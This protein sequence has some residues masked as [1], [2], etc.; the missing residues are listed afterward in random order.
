MIIHDRSFPHPVLAPFRDDVEPNTFDFTIKVSSDADNYYLNI[1]FQYENETLANL[2]EA[3]KAIHAVHIECKRNFYRH[4]FSTAKRAHTIVVPTAELVGKV[5]V[6]GFIK[7]QVPMAAYQITGAHAD[8][9]NATFEIK[10]GDVLAVAASHSFEAYVDYDPLRHISSILTI[11]RSDEDVEGDM[12]LDTMNDLIVVT[13]SQQDYDRYTGLKADPNLGP[14]L[15]NQVVIPA[16]LEAIHE[17]Q[18]THDDDLD[19]EMS[20]RW[21][22]S[23]YQKLVDL[24]ISIRTPDASAIEAL[25]KL[26]KLPLR[27][28][29]EGL[30]QLNPLE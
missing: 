12:K 1:A 9:G 26:L 16:L 21:F 24:G 2:V 23:V 29:L 5:E 7:A 13:L 20:K 17:I 27:R 14:L 15:A 25:Q 19:L 10:T 3:G 6:S 8:Y 28:S 18:D 11:R 4:V 22:R 30:I